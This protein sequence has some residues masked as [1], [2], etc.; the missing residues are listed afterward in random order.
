MR[1]LN[2]YKLSDEDLDF[3]IN[4]IREWLFDNQ[5]NEKYKTACFALDIALNARE[6]RKEKVGD[7]TSLVIDNLC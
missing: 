3:K 2:Y 4:Q 6:I 1:I 7:F 5:K